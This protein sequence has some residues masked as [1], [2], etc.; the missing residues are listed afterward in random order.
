VPDES[1]EV[2]LENATASMSLSDVELRDFF[3]IPNSLMHGKSVPAVA[4]FHMR[5]HGIN[6]RVHLHDTKNHFEARF[7]EDNATIRWRAHEKGFTF[8]SAPAGTSTTVFAE[9]GTERNGVFF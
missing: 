7:I 1:V 8:V 6:K 2:D 9:I 3:N 5:W 4:S